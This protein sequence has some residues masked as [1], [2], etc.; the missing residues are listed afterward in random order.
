[1]RAEACASDVRI[2]NCQPSQL[3][4]STPS[5]WSTIASSPLVTCSPEATTTSYSR[6][7]Y[8][9]LASRQKLTSRSVSP[10][11]AETTTATS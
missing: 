8:S 3:R 11:I 9:G 1:M 2:G 7:S 4:A 10:D 5:D 6:G